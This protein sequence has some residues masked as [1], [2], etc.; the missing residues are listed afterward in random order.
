M[1]KSLISRLFGGKAQPIII[2]GGRKEDFENLEPIKTHKG[3]PVRGKRKPDYRFE[4]VK[5]RRKMAR[6]SRKNNRK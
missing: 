2:R 1:L 3:L 6:Q 5:A 4:K